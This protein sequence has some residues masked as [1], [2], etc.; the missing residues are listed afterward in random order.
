[1]ETTVYIKRENQNPIPVRLKTVR[2][3]GN[4]LAV[5][6]IQTRTG[7]VRLTAMAA[8]KTVA[9]LIKRGV[10]K[11]PPEMATGA[12]VFSSIAK[13]TQSQAAQNVLKQAQGVV[14]HPLFMTAL[15]FIPGFGPAM[16]T[17]NKATAA[18]K[19]AQSLMGR[20]RQGDRKAQQ[21]VGV[22]ANSAKKGSKK[23]SVLMALL[24]AADG[25]I[26]GMFSGGNDA[27]TVEVND[28][29][30]QF[31]AG[32]WSPPWS[33]TPSSGNSWTP[34]W[35]NT[36]APQ[37]PPQ[38]PS[39]QLPPQTPSQSQSQPGHSATPPWPSQGWP[40]QPPMQP[41]GWPMQPPQGWSTAPQPPS[42]SPPQTPPWRPPGNAQPNS[43]PA[44]PYPWPWFPRSTPKC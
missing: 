36:P 34:P 44:Y 29:A 27:P 39:G 14:K 37:L 30:A 38:T 19:A 1:M 28:I 23:G 22:I 41:Q 6:E 26:R 17:M 21:S 33:P 4:W 25:A 11:V 35:G 12:D 9:D 18:V 42:W 10:A 32:S 13:L 31:G 8:E 24:Q 5:A 43:Q 15:S 3:N 40:Q 16:Q 20:A 2:Q 7:P